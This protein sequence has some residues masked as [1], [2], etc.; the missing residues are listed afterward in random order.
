ME[1][2]GTRSP[3]HV[4]SFQTNTLNSPAHMGR[5][6]TNPLFSNSYS[7]NRASDTSHKVEW[8]PARYVLCHL[9]IKC[10]V[11]FLCC[12]EFSMLFVVGMGMGLTFW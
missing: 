8:V 10:V 11:C 7:V 5:V 4:E 6:K 1:T 3:A 12:Q 2:D 9:D